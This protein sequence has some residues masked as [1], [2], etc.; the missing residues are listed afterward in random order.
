MSARDIEN[1]IAA[2]FIADTLASNISSISSST[3]TLA[4][5]EGTKWAKGDIV[6]LTGNNLPRVA[7]VLSVAGDVLTLDRAPATTTPGSGA[8]VRGGF[9][10]WVRPATGGEALIYIE[11]LIGDDPLK[12]FESSTMTSNCQARLRLLPSRGRVSQHRSEYGFELRVDGRDIEWCE[13]LLARTERLLFGRPSSLTVAASDAWNLTTG[14]AQPLPREATAGL[15][16]YVLPIF[17]V[18]AA[19]LVA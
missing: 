6:H 15:C 13:G 10:N 5:S 7:T 14:A 18:T 19:A 17:A 12:A 4:S 1:A 8:Q 9:A 3:V 2:R 16:R 11:P